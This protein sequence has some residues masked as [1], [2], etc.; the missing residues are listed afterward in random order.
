MNGILKI[1]KF[2]III[3]CLNACSNNAHLEY[4]LEYAGDNRGELERVLEHYKNDALKLKAAHFLIENMPGHYGVYKNRSGNTEVRQ[5][6][7]VITSDYLIRNIDASF[8]VWKQNP[9]YKYISFDNFCELILPYRISNEPLE[10]WREAYYREFRYVLDIA[11]PTEDLVAACQLI[12]LQ[13]QE[14]DRFNFHEIEPHVSPFE[15]KL[16]ND[17]IFFNTIMKCD[18]LMNFNVVVTNN[19]AFIGVGSYQDSM[20]KIIN[21]KGQ[22]TKGYFTYPY[23]NKT[24]GK[25]S[26]NVR[27]MAYQGTM[28]I[29]PSQ[30]KLVYV[31][32]YAKQ[33]YFFLVE[34]GKMQ[35]IKEIK[36]SYP[37]YIP[38]TSHGVSAIYDKKAP[39]GFTDV[40]TTDQFVYAL[41]SG[42]SFEEYGLQCSEGNKLFV[43]TWGGEL[44]DEYTLDIDINC[45]CVDNHDEIMYAIANNPDP[46]IVKFNIK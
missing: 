30:N 10:E 28:E 8:M 45:I 1:V 38:D 42:K 17:S 3:L 20:F 19:H 21:E 37:Q 32:S 24:E 31:T 13:I 41:Y 26:A 40:T 22:V 12:N 4:A 27:A 7:Q 5:D 34:E 9:W 16:Y 15:L 33:L 39:F 25:I 35:L 43:Y 46:Q 11:E 18:T 29:N 14:Y 23:K 2:S 36:D 6:A 44:V